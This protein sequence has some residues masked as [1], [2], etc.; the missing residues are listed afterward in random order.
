[1]H[2]SGAVAQFNFTQKLIFRTSTPCSGSVEP[3]YYDVWGL[4][5]KT[6][7]GPGVPLQSTSY[8]VP[9]GPVGTDKHKWT[10]VTRPDGTQL[11]FKHGTDYFTNEGKLLQEQTLTAS[12]A[13]VK[14]RSIVYV[15]DS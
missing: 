1:T 5:T 3:G 13:I 9:R 8:S 14:D 2:P 4:D 11:R 7:S 12:E 10:T 6:V 15:S